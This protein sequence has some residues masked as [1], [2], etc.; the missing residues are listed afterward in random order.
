MQKGQRKGFTLVEILVTTVVIAVLAA[1]VIPAMAK[2]VTAGDPVRM[3]S[4][5][6]NVK[7]GIEVFSNNL[8]P[9][10]PGDIDDLVNPP[11]D[12]GGAGVD[13]A[14]DGTSYTSTQVASWKGP[15]VEWSMSD[16]TI[17][18]SSSASAFRTANSYDVLN[19]FVR[20]DGSF[21]FAGCYTTFTNSYVSI[22]VRNMATSD[23][24]RLNAVIDG[25]ESSPSSTGLV[26][27]DGTTTVG[28]VYYLST[29][30]QAP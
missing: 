15:Y 27:F 11:D 7:T 29:P 24:L 14:V 16:A 20:C 4:D 26:R 21:T 30:Y 13:K 5:L 1:I 8:R 19:G 28:N 17:A 10:F 9:R 23:F 18:A 12:G 22:V 6:N 25:T 2:Q 3:A